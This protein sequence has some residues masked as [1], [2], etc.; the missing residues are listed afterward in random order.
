MPS[1]SGEGLDELGVVLRAVERDTDVTA[2][3][4]RD[5]VS[6]VRAVHGPLDRELAGLV[7]ASLAFG[8]ADVVVAKGREV[9]TRLGAPLSRAADHPGEVARRL[10]GFRH[11]L[12]GAAELTALLVGARRVQR[13]HGT[14]GDRLA[15]LLDEARALRPALAAFVHEIRAAGGL[16]HLTTRGAAHILPDPD[17]P[18]ASKRLFLYLRWMVR[19]DDGVDLGLWSRVS[20]ALLLVPMDV[21]LSRLSRNLRLTDRKGASYA[22]AEEVTAQLRR[23]DPRDPVR[24]DFSLC[25]L[26]M[27]RDCPSHR[28]EERCAGCGV[29][30]LCR[31]W[32]RGRSRRR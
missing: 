24:F 21:H 5:P 1:P 6:V 18:S 14:L 10:R 17:G 12:Y 4:A 11:R 23:L 27:A 8:N 22:L 26:G 32:Q 31:H 9:L 29:K 7:V 28:D 3:L 30:P 20:P 13:V 2:R 16:D 15:T 25:H 19:P